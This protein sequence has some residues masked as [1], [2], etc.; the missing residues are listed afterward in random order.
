MS[1]HGKTHSA[2][3]KAKMSASRIGKK[4]P[5]LTLE[6]KE[7]MSK[8]L[9]GQKRSD[10]TRAKM[11]A[12]SKGKPKSLEHAA[13]NRKHGFKKGIENINANG[14]SEEHRRKISIANEGNYSHPHTPESKK[15]LSE[16]LI[17][18]NLKYG[19]KGSGGRGKQGRRDDLNCF[20][21]STWEANYAR[22]LNYCGIG[23]E[24]EKTRFATP[25]GTYCPDFYLE[26]FNLYV[27]V[28]GWDLSDIQPRKRQWLKE[29]DINFIE[30]NGER[31]KNLENRYSTKINSWE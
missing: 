15:K 1:M 30:I 29:Q 28:K 11:S 27:E 2:E 6:H 3:T 10:E 9:T 23:W 25:Y 24:F 17:R 4:L 5:S 14:L 13:K 20:F 18:H 12:S 7:K 8:A 22:Y 31:Y 21:R 26:E 19:Y 16:S